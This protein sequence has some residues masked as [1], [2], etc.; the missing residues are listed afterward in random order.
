MIVWK[1]STQVCL[2]P[3]MFPSIYVTNRLLQS[4]TGTGIWLKEYIPRN[5]DNN[6]FIE[7]LLSQLCM[8]GLC[9]VISG[10]FTAF[11]AGMIDSYNIN[12]SYIT[13]TDSIT[14]DN[15]LGRNGKGPNFT[16][17]SFLFSF[18][19]QDSGDYTITYNGISLPFNIFPID[20][21]EECGSHSNLNFVKLIWNFY[22]MKCEM[23]AITAVHFDENIRVLYLKNHRAAGD[24]WTL[25]SFCYTRSN[26]HKINIVRNFLHTCNLSRN[27][28][29][30]LSL[31]QPSSLRSFA[32]QTV[33]H[34]R[35][36]IEHFK[37]SH[38]TICDQ[39]VYA[40]HSR[41]S[42]FSKF[43]SKFIS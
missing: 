14:L 24:S 13:I 27:Y 6:N 28:S 23:F 4:R 36:N 20:T 10:T 43:D 22:M 38:E 11:T 8:M 33:F 32:S 15:I 31:S 5:Y 7:M 40:I 1:F 39:F 9:C 25:R 41:K 26:Y 37:L 16:I 30:N 34:I 17:G 42:S 3:Q 19:E 18:G 35:F 2:N 21:L 12:T 29:C